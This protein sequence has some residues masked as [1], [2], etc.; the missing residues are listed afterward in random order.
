VKVA[1]EQEQ[2]LVMFVAFSYP[3]SSRRMYYLVY[4]ATDASLYMIPFIPDHIVCTYTTTPVPRFTG[5]RDHEPRPPGPQVLHSDKGE[6]RVQ[7]VQV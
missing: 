6:R 7:R 4:D 3:Q 1:T 2:L 5:G